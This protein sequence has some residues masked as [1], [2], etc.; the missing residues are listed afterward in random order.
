MPERTFFTLRYALSG[1]TS[2]LMALLVAYPKLRDIFILNQNVELIG[3]FLAFFTLLSGGAIGFLVSQLYYIINNEFLHRHALQKAREFLEGKYNITKDS[4]HQIVFLDYVH[5]L[6]GKE[7]IAYTQRRFDLKHTLASALFATYIGSFFGLL[8]RIN[9]L[10]TDITLEKAINSLLSIRVHL[11]VLGLTTYDFGVIL[12]IA[13]FS[14]LLFIS[15]RYIS[16]EHAMMV[17]ISV[18]RVV[19]S[20]IF[21][22][23]K[24]KEYFPEDYFIKKATEKRCKT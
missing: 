12:I 2:I 13:T 21:P 7:T 9:C 23:A 3:V 16:K 8:V 11:Y 20:G 24:A 10:R 19:K 18:R 5:H 22:E 6:S 17:L 4:H 1:Y 14:I 15:Y